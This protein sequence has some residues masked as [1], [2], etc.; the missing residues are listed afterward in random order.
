MT[1]EKNKT[2]YPY[3]ANVTITT[4]IENAEHKNGVSLSKHLKIS[5]LME[6]SDCLA[7][8]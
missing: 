3:I 5:S 8:Y 2:A 7:T 1:C 6:K 4:S